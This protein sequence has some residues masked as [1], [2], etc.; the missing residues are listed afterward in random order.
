MFINPRSDGAFVAAVDGAMADGI[1]PAP[2]PS[3][4][5]DCGWPIRRSSSASTIFPETRRPS[6]SVYRDGCW[7]PEAG[8]RVGSSPS[9]GPFRGDTSLRHLD[10]L[11]VAG[12]GRVLGARGRLLVSAG[13]GELAVGGGG[14][15]RV[16]PRRWRPADRSA[17]LVS[18]KGRVRSPLHRM[19]RCGRPVVQRVGFTTIRTTMTATINTMLPP[20]RFTREL[21]ARYSPESAPPASSAAICRRRVGL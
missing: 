14:W 15:H 8:H 7:T 20:T 3:S 4:R 21:R 13:R 10:R 1:G 5:R 11:P 9:R 16:R 6:G 18:L 12:V 17:R 2:R 19:R